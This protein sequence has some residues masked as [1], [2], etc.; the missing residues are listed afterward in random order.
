MLQA[1][2]A[3]VSNNPQINPSQFRVTT[4]ATGLSFPTSMTR[5]NDGSIVVG[6]TIPNNPAFTTGFESFGTGVGQF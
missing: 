1:T 6:T 4:F 3:V 2:P 5:L